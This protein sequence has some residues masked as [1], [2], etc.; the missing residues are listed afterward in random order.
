[1]PIID[2]RIKL[3]TGNDEIGDSTRVV[4]VDADN[5]R[6]GLVVD[7]VYEVTRIAKDTIFAPPQALSGEQLK[8]LPG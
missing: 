6:I 1:M 4:V 8:G 3:D 2:M 5:T 7:R